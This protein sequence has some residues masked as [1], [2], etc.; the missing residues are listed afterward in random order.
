M[1]AVVCTAYGAPEVLVVRDVPR[2]DPRPGEVR[3]RVVATTAHVGDARVRRADPF[4]ARFAFGL[5]RPRR[6]LILGLEL[7]GVVDALGTGVS[8]FVLGDE[9][10]AFCGFG[11]GGN[12]EYRCLPVA[13]A[14]AQ[15]SGAIVRKPA[16][17]SFQEAAALPA[18][19]LTALK[20]L[21]KARLGA[22]DRI[23]INGASGSLGTF[24]IQLAKH[25]GAEVT[26]VC[27]GRNRELVTD[28]GA[29]LVIDHETEDFTRLGPLF[30]VVYDAVGLSS[31]RACGGLLRP[32][33]VHVRNAGLTRITREDL[34]LVADLADRGVLR[35]VIDR[36]LPLDQVVDA[37]R[38]VDTGHKRGNVVLTA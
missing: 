3:I 36:V 16:S 10:M 5:F 30:D 25:M 14:N 12:A 13:A 33:G 37:H 7:A 9:V 24:A 1:K 11:F 6:D 15:K 28:L 34:Q 27:S 31:R 17:L 8:G 4:A 21:Q 19:A 38:Y 23:L 32:G 29:D 20:N 35:P 26:A 22:G 18:G 2:P